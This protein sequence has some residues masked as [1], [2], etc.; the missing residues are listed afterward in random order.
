MP[1]PTDFSD[2]LAATICERLANGETLRQLCLDE[3]MPG[4]STVYRWLEAHEGFRDQYARVCELRADAW[5]DELLEIADETA[6]DT[7]RNDRG[8]VSADSEWISRSKL[9]V[10][11]RKWLMARAAP[12]KY[13]DKV[14][15]ELT[16]AGGGPVL[17]SIEVRFVD[18]AGGS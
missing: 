11:A 7:K 12:K 3:A 18:A 16:G 9:R 4:R 8:D 10:D 6:F 5:A 15:T 2:E 14:T 13:G 1:R 17:T